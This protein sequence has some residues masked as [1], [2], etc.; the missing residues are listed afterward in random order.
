MR[1]PHQRAD[2]K[3]SSRR[4]PPQPH[5]G[6]HPREW[7][8]GHERLVAAIGGVAGA[9]I[10]RHVLRGTTMAPSGSVASKKRKRKVDEGAFSTWTG[11]KPIQ[12]TSMMSNGNGLNRCC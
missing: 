4:A 1:M 11:E 7:R 8:H 9:W 2:S 6:G 5:D 3:R 12:P 10:M